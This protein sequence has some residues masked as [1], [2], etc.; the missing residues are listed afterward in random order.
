MQSCQDNSF[1]RSFAR[2]AR[3]AVLLALTSTGCQQNSPSVGSTAPWGTPTATSSAQ[4]QQIDMMSDMWRRQNE[5]TQASLT[6]M[7]RRQAQQ[8][9][10]MQ[11]QAMEQARVAQEGKSRET[12]R[13]SRLARNQQQNAQQIEEL[14][15]RAMELDT[16][17]R[18]LHA[19][20]A[21][22]QQKNRLLEDQIKPLRQQLSD[23]AKQLSG[24]LQAKQE[25]DKKV[26]AVQASTRRRGGATITANSSLRRNLTAISVAGIQVRQDGDVVRMELPSDTIFVTKSATI[27]PSSLPIIQQVAEAIADNYPRQIIGV[28]AYTD[29]DPVS[30]TAWRSSHQ[31][32]AA[33]AMAVFDQL[34]QHKGLSAR[35]LFVLGHGP[36]HPIASNSSPAGKAR[37]RRVEI[38]VYP[39]TLDA[40]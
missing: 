38:V 35:Q 9:N 25:L 3:I 14:R 26:I 4:Q 28:E 8:L 40:R 5:Q 36:N 23:T 21:K 33:Q 16:N 18:D 2:L 22:S 27:N 37:N 34:A 19:Q 6:E 29:S 24:T 1:N 39:E 15:R 30:G 10:E 7:E 12:E 20:L 31:L 17:N 13:Q 32:S 11:R